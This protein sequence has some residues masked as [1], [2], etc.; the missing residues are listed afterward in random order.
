MSGI[1]KVLENSFLY[2]FSSLLVKAIGFIL[3][4]VYTKF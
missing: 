3:L 2:T 4:P 1:R